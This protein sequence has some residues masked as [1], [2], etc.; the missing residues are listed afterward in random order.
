MSETPPIPKLQTLTLEATDFD[1]DHFLSRAYDDVSLACT[2]LPPIMEWLGEQLHLMRE[3]YYRVDQQ[4]DEARAEAFLRLSSAAGW[5]D[6]G[7][8]GKMTVDAIKYAVVLDP[9]VKR[10]T[11][12]HGRL[13]AWCE[14]L[15]GT[16]RNFTA[17]LELIRS[18]E[19]T[20]RKVYEAGD[21][22]DT[23]NEEDN[24]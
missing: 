22:G 2:T 17:K 24:D 23:T 14:R 12:T 18:S 5:E 3:D 1:L 15:R 20:R 16:Q 4:L 8:S 9:D 21:I 11:A 13:S 19:A 6:A 7:Y 10:L